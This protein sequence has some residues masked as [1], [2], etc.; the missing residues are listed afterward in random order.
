MGNLITRNH[1]LSLLLQN[2]GET[3]PHYTYCS[4]HHANKSK[5]KMLI[6]TR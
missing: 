5:I 1:L 3:I 2:I 6:I 4:F